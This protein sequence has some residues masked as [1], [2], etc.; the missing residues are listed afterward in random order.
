MITEKQKEIRMVGW[1]FT[2]GYTIITLMWQSVAWMENNIPAGYPFPAA[3]ITG[4][5]PIFFNAWLIV[6]LLGIATG[7][8]YLLRILYYVSFDHRYNCKKEVV[9]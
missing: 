3:E 5:V 9:R 4:A 6:T 2:L 8:A 1:G 7:V